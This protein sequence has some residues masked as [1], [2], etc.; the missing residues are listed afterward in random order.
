[1]KTN[2]T[3]CPGGRYVWTC[4]TAKPELIKYFLDYKIPFR[5]RPADGITFAMEI[6][7]AVQLCTELSIELACEGED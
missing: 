7:E 4:E 2:F 6:S 1:M 5:Y 3:L